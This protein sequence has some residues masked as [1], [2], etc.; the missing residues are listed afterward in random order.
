MKNGFYAK[1]PQKNVQS[2]QPNISVVLHLDAN[3]KIHCIPCMVYP[4]IFPGQDKKAVETS[5]RGERNKMCGTNKKREK[6]KKV[7]STF[8]FHFLLWCKHAFF[9]AQFLFTFWGLHAL[10][11]T[12]HDHIIGLGKGNPIVT[13]K[14]QA[15]YKDLSQESSRRRKTKW[16]SG[17]QA[18]N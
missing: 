3:P 2:H 10:H 5:T 8:K 9:L 14:C 6:R 11:N 7:R 1:K 15:T 17:K 18:K 4:E 13:I 16:V 12:R